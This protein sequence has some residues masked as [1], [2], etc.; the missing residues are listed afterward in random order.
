MGTCTSRDRS[1]NHE[2]LKVEFPNKTHAMKR[3]QMAE[4]RK[5]NPDATECDM[6]TGE[7]P[8]NRPGETEMKVT[9]DGHNPLG[10]RSFNDQFDFYRNSESDLIYDSHI[11][12]LLRNGKRSSQ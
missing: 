9:V 4:C 3:T 1:S 2:L 7:I 10:N 5:P 11:S 8:P 6:E 12:D